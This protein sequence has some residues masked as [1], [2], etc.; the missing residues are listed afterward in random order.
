LGRRLGRDDIGVLRLDLA[1]LAYE[2]V[3]LRVTELGIVED[4]V[5]LG[6]VIDQVAERLGA[7]DDLLRCGRGHARQIS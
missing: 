4:E 5:T 1:Q 2:R 3:E 7:I 6:V